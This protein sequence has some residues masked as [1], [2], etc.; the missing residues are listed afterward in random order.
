LLPS[1]LALRLGTLSHECGDNPISNLTP[2]LPAAGR[3]RRCCRRP[4]FRRLRW[5]RGVAATDVVRPARQ[6]PTR[7]T[8]PQPPTRLLL[9]RRCGGSAAVRSAP[10]FRRCRWMRF[11]GRPPLFPSP[12]PLSP[13][14]IGRSSF[15]AAA[16]LATPLRPPSFFSPPPLSPR[17]IGSPLCHA[18]APLAPTHR[19]PLFVS[20][21]PLSLR[22]I[23]SPSLF[24]RRPSRPAPS[25]PSAA[26][27]VAPPSLLPHP[28]G[29][30][31]LG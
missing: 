10:P 23:G 19:Q 3:L 5:R 21:P 24:R 2:R 1:W 17:P 16:P 4:A 20:P 29:R 22:L 11:F 26:L 15:A 6:P 13:R 12:P 28:I 14:P 27:F 8:L 31:R 7:L 18:A 25:V 9:S 30:S